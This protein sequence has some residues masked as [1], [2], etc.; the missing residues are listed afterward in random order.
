MHP[1]PTELQR[2]HSLFSFE[3]GQFAG[4]LYRP[5]DPPPAIF[6]KPRQPLVF[7]GTC[8]PGSGR[9]VGPFR[10]P[11]D[12][13]S[14]EAKN[15]NQAE[16]GLLLALSQAERERHHHQGENRHATDQVPRLVAAAH[17]R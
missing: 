16:A 17:R 7:G 15:L 11:A 1:V 6:A 5:S 2:H 9:V 8:W 10:E 4:G 13:H 14:Q 12:H 3:Y